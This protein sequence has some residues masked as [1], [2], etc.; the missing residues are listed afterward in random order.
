MEIM[1]RPKIHLVS[2]ASPHFLHRQWV[3]ATSARLNGV[4]ETTRSWNRRKLLNAG[5]EDRV[6]NISLKERGAG[7]WAWKPF[8]IARRLSELPEGEI[9]LYCDVGRIFPYKKLAYP[10]DPLLEWMEENSQDVLPGVNIPWFGTMGNWTKRDAL[11][12]AGLDRSDIHEAP[13]VQASFSLWR[14]SP[15]A[16]SFNDQWMDWCSR[17]QLVSGEPSSCGLPELHTFREHRFDQALL[18][19]CCFKLGVRALD[20]GQESPVRDPRNPSEVAMWL[21]GHNKTVITPA[22]RIFDCL[23]KPFEKTERL[24]RSGAFAL[25]Q[26][27]PPKANGV[28]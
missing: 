28:S 3:L 7:F 18:S 27:L 17:R 2:Y 14:N 20:I 19:L 16:R 6:E 9:V 4:V 8:V 1:K 24:A 11:V 12:E 23:T 5:F 15:S 26:K 25:R 21:A 10:L 13:Q 22:G